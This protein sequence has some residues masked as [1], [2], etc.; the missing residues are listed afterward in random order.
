MAQELPHPTAEGQDDGRLFAPSAARNLAPILSAIRPFV[1][2]RGVALEIASGTGEHAVAMARAF[3]DTIWQPTDID[4]E[5][6][7]S[8]DAWRAHKGAQNM[9]VAQVLDATAPSWRTGP[10][11]MV[12]TVNLMHLI[13]I[14]AAQAVINGVARNLSPSGHWFLYGPF[15]IGGAFRSDGDRVFHA[16]LTDQNPGAGYK[17]IEAVETWAADAGL[18]RV[19]LIEMPANN[20]ALVMRQT[21]SHLARS[22]V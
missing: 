16:S 5:R 8:I 12:M 17:D 21:R 11:A 18:T 15:R 13:D 6:L 1:P 4:A 3:P 14:Q 9:R 22:D 2:P 20:L 7:I 19:D 10:F